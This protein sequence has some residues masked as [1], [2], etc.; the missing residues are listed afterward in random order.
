MEILK[1]FIVFEGLDGAGTSTQSRLL[2]EKINNSFFTCEPTS[3]PIGKM[4]RQI[5]KKEISVT[6]LTLAYLFS[7]D[8]AEHVYGACGVLEKCNNGQI[9][10][11]DRYLFSSLAYQSL[12]IDFETVLKMNSDFPL[13]EIVIFLNTSPNICQERIKNRSN[14]IELFEENNMQDKILNNYIKGF[15]YFKNSEIK[16]YELNGSLP[17]D[18]LLNEEINIL[19]NNDIV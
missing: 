10:I 7:G 13:P 9:V 2:F 4:I 18:E 15:S 8:R 19:K 3:G 12:N 14:D 1:N 5:L 6:P 17:I 11:S 16:I